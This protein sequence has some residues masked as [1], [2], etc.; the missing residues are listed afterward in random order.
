[1]SSIRL[2]HGGGS[3]RLGPQQGHSFRWFGPD[4]DPP[5][6][7]RCVHCNERYDQVETIHWCRVMQE[8][9]RGMNEL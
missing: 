4:P 5:P 8:R 3:V 9:N 7:S 6:D 1:M 2:G